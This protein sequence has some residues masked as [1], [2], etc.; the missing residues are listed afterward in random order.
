MCPIPLMLMLLTALAT[1][2]ALACEVIAPESHYSPEERLD[3]IDAA[4]I[5]TARPLSISPPTR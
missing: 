3:R 5:A 2:S 1:S 4:L